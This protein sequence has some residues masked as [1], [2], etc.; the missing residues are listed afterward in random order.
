LLCKSG[1][2]TRPEVSRPQTCKATD[3]QGHRP[4]TEYAKVNSS[5]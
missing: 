1:M 2:L 3:V 5:S 4:K